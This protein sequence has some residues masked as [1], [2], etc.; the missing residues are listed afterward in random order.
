VRRRTT[1]AR[2]LLAGAM[3]VG[4]LLAGHTLAAAPA[5]AVSGLTPVTR[6][7]QANSRTLKRVAAVCPAGTRV[8]GG[9][10]TVVNGG[11]Q[12]V[13]QQLEPRHTVGDDRF[14]VAA[15]EDRTG[16]ASSWRLTAY[17]LCADPLAGQQ[18]TSNTLPA[19][20]DSLQSALAVCPSGQTQIGYG[21][22][23]D[24]GAGQVHVTELFDFFGPPV[25]VTFL[26]AREGAGRY[27][28]SW[29]VRPFAVC[30]DAA[31]VTGLVSVATVSPSSSL[32]KSAV[33]SCP[34]GTQV[35]SAGG[36]LLSG[37]GQL[38]T[39]SLIIDQISVDP[40]ATT[41]TVRGVEDEAGTLDPWMVR[42]VALCG[43]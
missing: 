29:A 33:V 13:L 40:S 25:G 38:A 24:N 22:R 16:Y 35:H 14:V 2:R 18:I 19:S 30:V 28:G 37:S 15:R 20:S 23:I 26:R 21:G 36:A 34:P 12:V 39:G 31:A 1:R 6:S 7:S 10:G 42:A 43:P 5:D 11:G 4:G 32:N 3:V 27:A 17:A 9:G 41:V 8:L